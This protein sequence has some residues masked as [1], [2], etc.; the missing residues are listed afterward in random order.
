MSKRKD[1]ERAESGL[2]FRNEPGKRGRLVNRDEWYKAN[3]T[4]EMLAEKQKKVDE[5]VQQ[6]FLRK[7]VEAKGIELPKGGGILIVKDGRILDPK[8]TNAV[9]AE[10]E[11]YYCTRCKVTHRKGAT[12]KAHLKYRST[13]DIITNS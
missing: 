4:P 2:I 9:M 6:S 11:P 12:H 8:D 7:A 13:A 1:R 3:P 5:A 10:S